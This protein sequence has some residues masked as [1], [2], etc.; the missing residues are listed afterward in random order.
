MKAKRLLPILLLTL[1][2]ALSVAMLAACGHEHQ[3]SKAITTEATCEGKGLL[4]YTCACGESYT[5]ETA[6]LGHNLQTHQAQDANCNQIGWDAYK[7]CT[8]RDYTTYQEQPITSEHTWDGGTITQNPT[9]TTKG[10]KTFACTVCK[11]ATR[12]EDVAALDHDLQTHQAKEPTCTEDGWYQYQT[13]NRDGCNYSTYKMRPGG[14]SYDGIVCTACNFPAPSTRGLEFTLNHDGN[15][16]TCTGIGSCASTQIFIGSYNNKPV[17]AIGEE[18]FDG[19]SDLTSV[20]IGN[21]VTTLGDHAFAGCSNLTSIVIPNS[22]T[23]IGDFAFSLCSNLTS[24]TIGNSVTSIGDR[25]FSLCSNLTSIVIP[26]S[27]TSIG[28]RAFSSCSN[29]TSIQVANN[30]PNYCSV[31]GNLYNKNKTTLIQYACGKTATTFTIPDSVTHIGKSAFSWCSNLTSIVIPN[32]VTSIGE[33]AFHMCSNL[34]SIVIPNSVTSIGYHA[35][36]NC[37]GLTSIII[38][39]S[40]TTIGDSA[41][42]YCSNLT[43]VTIGNSVTS[44]GNRAFYGCSN[45]TSVTLGNSVTSIGEEVFYGCSNLTSIVIPNSVTSIGY[46]AFCVCSNLTSI[47]IPDSVTPIGGSAFAYC[48][49]LTIY[50]KATEKPSGWSNWWNYS[51]CPVYWAGQWHYDDNG[52]P[53]P[54]N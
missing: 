51:D 40:V 50:C 6:S 25:A 1:V 53:T 17:T 38:P 20:T 7:T 14:H 3:Y 28:D 47:V 39:N 23:S 48:Y 29:L 54:N 12:T 52:K 36:Y 22:V 5:E 26:D 45:L 43:S 19:C 8:R 34:T 9:C 35:F 21:S 37:D 27:V 10:V 15:S 24:V 44:I 33:S 30:N 11:N 16:Y 41:F 31:D 2:L 49:N 13:C 46:Y 4:T 32:S 42:C 18:A